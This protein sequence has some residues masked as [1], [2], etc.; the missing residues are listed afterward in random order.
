VL[1]FGLRAWRKSPE[2]G[3]NA[4]AAQGAYKLE[5]HRAIWWGTLV[6]STLVLLERWGGA[7]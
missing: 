2:A 1:F 7:R 5:L 4:F 3:T 6:L